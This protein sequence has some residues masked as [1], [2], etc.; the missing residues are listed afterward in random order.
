MAKTRLTSARD[1]TAGAGASFVFRGTVQQARASNVPDVKSS[2]RTAIVRIDDVMAAPP[3]LARAGGQEVTVLLDRDS[4]AVRAGEQAVFYATGVSFG[5]RIALRAT[6]AAPTAVVRGIGA[7]RAAAAPLS[8]GGVVDPVQAHRDLLL[9]RSLD[10]ADVVVAGTVTQVKVADETEDSPLPARLAMRGRGA[11][12]QTMRQPTRI[13]EHDP[14]WHEAVVSVDSVEK[15]TST[16]KQVVVRFPGSNDVRWRY[17][18]KLRVGQQGVFLLTPEGPGRGAKGSAATVRGAAR[19]MTALAVP[20][21][22]NPMMH[23]TA[24]PQPIGDLDRVRLLLNQSP[25]ANLAPA[26]TPEATSAGAVRRSRTRAAPRSA[27]ARRTRKRS[28]S[29]AKGR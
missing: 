20:T 24:D 5:E 18:P 1:A 19:R 26:L 23:T 21:V 29:T 27:S 10:Q 3:T 9:K 14:I 16:R 2:A 7:A 6:V 22:Q 8:A 15:G 13:S 17:H 11:Q 12:A 25:N 4:R 28:R